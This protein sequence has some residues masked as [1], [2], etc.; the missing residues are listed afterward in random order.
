MGRF[1]SIGEALI[2]MIPNEIGVDLKNV[3]NFTRKAGGAP[4]NVCACVAKQGIEAAFIGKLGADA[5]GEYLIETMQRVGVNTDYVYKTKEANT[6]LAFASLMEDGERDFSFYRNPGADMLLDETEI[7]IE[8]FKADD[9]LHFCSVDLIEAPVKYAHRKAIEAVKEKGGT[10]V[11]DPNLRFPL[12]DDKEELRLTV[13]EFAAFADI[14]KI[15]DNELFFITDT[16][17]PKE[18]AQVMFEKG[19]KAVLYTMGSSGARLIT[20]SVDIYAP[21]FEVMP[22]NT[23]GAGDAFI[24]GFIAELIRSRVDIEFIDKQLAEGILQIANA[25]GA[26]VASQH[27]AIEVMPTP[28]EINEFILKSNK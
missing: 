15:S 17:D 4:A 1:F 12:W 2:D 20:K 18:A 11:F 5:F 14:I 25:C 24:G 21:A 28:N 13:L 27:G 10:I 26:M 23:T 8:W 9:F 16:Q 19:V 7:D 6:T 3:D 22:I